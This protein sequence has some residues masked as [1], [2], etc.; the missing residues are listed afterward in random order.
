MSNMGRV[1]GKT[2]LVTGA[3]SG[4]GRAIAVLL[5]K[6]G[7]EVIVADISETAGREVVDEINAD[8]G[9]AF[10]QKLDVTDEAGWTQVSAAIMERYG[11]LDVLVNNAGV[12]ERGNTED[13]TLGDWK[14][15]IDVNLNGVFLGTQAAMEV[16]KG[17]GGSIINISSI[18]GMI[19]DADLSAYTASKGGVRSFT[20]SSALLC[21]REGYKI[22]IN[23]INPGVIRTAL[24]DAH[25][26]NFEDPETE[27]QRLAVKHPIGFLGSPDDVAYGVL[28]LAS[29]ESCFVTGSELVIDGGYTA[30]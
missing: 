30:Q 8:G 15:V 25:L 17:T 10:F 19:G 7:A 23:A 20:K 28:Y 4:I 12:T 9:K 5:A 6:Q 11:R 24:L 29:D 2:A 16:M 13:I 22:R 3:A 18:E 26:E 27:Y 1:K 21:A 14:A